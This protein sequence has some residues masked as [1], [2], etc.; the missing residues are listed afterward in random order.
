MT[1]SSGSGSGTLG[2]NLV[3]DNSIVDAYNQ[4][5]VNSLGGPNGSF[6]GQAYTV[7]RA[8]PTNSLSLVAQTGGA[9]YLAGSTVFYRGTGSG[10]GG[11]FA[12][13]NTA[14]DTGGSA[15]ASSTTAAL[16]GTATGWTHTPGT[17]R[18]R[19][20]A[21]STRTR[22]AGRKARRASRPRP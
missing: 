15:L 16:A 4:P 13:R 17:A 22:S 20:A 11:S 19:P 5:L 8:A 2:L 6:T 3:D 9:S 14:S 12:I 7:D 18:H 10:S 1:A 21:R